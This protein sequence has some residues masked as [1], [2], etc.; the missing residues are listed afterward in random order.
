MDSQHQAEKPRPQIFMALP[1]YGQI[2]PDVAKAFWCE[3]ATDA[4]DTHNMDVGSSLLAHAFNQLWCAA[5][6]FRRQ[7]PVDY[8]V[9]LHADVVPERFWVDKLVAEMKRTRA[10]LISVVV[11]IKTPHG[12]TSTAIAGE[13]VWQPERRLTMREVMRLPETFSAADCG[14]PSRHLLV[15]TGCWIADLSKFWALDHEVRFQ[16]SNR[17]TRSVDGN[18]ECAVEPEDWAFSRLIQ[19]RGGVVLATRKVAVHHIGSSAYGNQ[20]A[21]GTLEVDRL[22]DDEPLPAMRRGA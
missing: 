22:A 14:Y 6:N 15:N 16:I 1:H 7:H 20:T 3:A 21:W 8:F 11:P 19:E 4:I 13:T 18:L 2:E 12:V 10:D 5:L 9:M 17:I